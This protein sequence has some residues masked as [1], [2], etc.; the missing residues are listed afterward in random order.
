MAEGS[1]AAHEVLDKLLADSEGDFLRDALTWLLNQLMDADVS[2]QIGALLH[3]RS[4]SRTTHRNGYRDR[5]W[6]T[7]AGTL[8]LKVPKLRKGT[9]QPPFLEPR[10]RLGGGPVGGAR[11]DAPIDLERPLE[12]G[13]IGGPEDGAVSLEFF[14]RAGDQ[15]ID[16]S[17]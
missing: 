17:A 11:G 3:E 2:G 6:D 14:L 7:R 10:R 4:T 13:Q 8:S 1:F 16:L 15:P 12:L 9:Y 5:A